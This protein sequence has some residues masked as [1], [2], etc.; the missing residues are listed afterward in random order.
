MEFDAK[1]N[2]VRKLY[3][4]ETPTVRA[5]NRFTYFPPVIDFSYEAVLNSLCD[6]IE[7]EEKNGARVVDRAETSKETTLSFDEL[8]KRAQELWTELVGTGDNAR[9]EVAA[10][11]LKKIEII[12]SRKM[13]LS[14][15]T[16]GQ[17]EL[18]N[19]VIM[20]MEEMRRTAN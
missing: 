14:E 4:R 10:T 1:G 13:K 20:D 18:L 12:M 15:F 19:L 7:Q 8:R 11:I 9:P 17:E 5:G 2:P 3:T 6:A 16:E